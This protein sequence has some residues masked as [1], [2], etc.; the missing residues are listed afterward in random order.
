MGLLFDFL[1]D[2]FVIGTGEVIVSLFRLD[3]DDKSDFAVRTF[4]A[5]E[6]FVGLFFWIAVL[7]ILYVI[8]W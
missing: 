4:P 8:I 7:A 1:I 2:W 5:L 3:D 6:L